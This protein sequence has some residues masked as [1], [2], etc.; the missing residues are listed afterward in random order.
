MGIAFAHDADPVFTFFTH[1]DFSI[2]IARW[3][4]GRACWPRTIHPIWCLKF[5]RLFLEML[6][7][8]CSQVDINGSEW[9][10]LLAAARREERLF[11]S[12]VDKYCL[13]TLLTVIMATGSIHSRKIRDLLIACST[14]FVDAKQCLSMRR[15]LNRVRIECIS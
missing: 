1:G 12:R 10:G 13:G 6:N 3:N 9:N 2:D 15:G 11:S 5:H 7:E 4:K 14:C 8:L